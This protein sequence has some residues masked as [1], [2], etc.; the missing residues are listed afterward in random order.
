ML[1]Y[2]ITQ[3]CLNSLIQLG[4]RNQRVYLM[5][6]DPRDVPTIIPVLN[7]LATE[8]RYTKIFAKI[9]KAHGEAF[10]NEG[11]RMEAVVPG[12]Y[13]GE[14]DGLF[15]G[16]YLNPKRSQATAPERI[17]KNLALAAKRAESGPDFRPPKQLPH[18]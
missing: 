9:P 10:L 8:N 6:L 2:D 14:E 15:L 12:L 7:R 17:E 18:F 16:F 13:N 11:Y 3:R 4:P 5:K 1:N